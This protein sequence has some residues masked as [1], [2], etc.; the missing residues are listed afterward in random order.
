MSGAGPEAA[1][2]QVLT[3]A[4]QL[5]NEKKFAEALACYEQGIR[6]LLQAAKEV[7]D[8]SKRTHF[9]KKTEE[10]LSRAEAMKEAA[11]KQRTIGRNHKQIQIDAGAIGY[12]YEAI[13][14]PL[15]DKTL[16]CVVVED[17]YIRSTHQIYNFLQFCELLVHK[18][19]CL[20]SITLQTTRDPADHKTQHS[21]LE[22]IRQSLWK[23]NITLTVEYS[24]TIHDRE[25]R[26]DSGWIIKIGRG[27]D[28]FKKAE[29]RFSLGW[30]D[31]H[32]R[33]CHQTTIDIFHQ[34]SVK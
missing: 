31:Y 20:K 33:Q 12:S 16:S 1:A 7:Q 9:R 8:D 4:V 27:L 15:I 10:Y 34:Q 30:S 21:R 25:I 5:D 3:R 11:D 6:L 26:F 22:E 14:G 18:A 13:F 32:F 23:H 29:G 28:Y 2:V 19:E 24:D 17:A